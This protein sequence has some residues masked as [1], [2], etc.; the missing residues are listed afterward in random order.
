MSVP[1]VGPRLGANVDKEQMATLTGQK[2]GQ[3]PTFSCSIQPSVL[4]WHWQH[5][6]CDRDGLDLYL[7]APS[8]LGQKKEQNRLLSCARSFF[9]N[10]YQTGYGSQAILACIKVEG[11]LE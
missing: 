7:N 4:Q 6:M 9:S 2:T 8:F 1:R 11:H 5:G 3:F 10:S